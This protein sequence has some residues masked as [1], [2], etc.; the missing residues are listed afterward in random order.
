GAGVVAAGPAAA[1]PSLPAGFAVQ[2]M[3]SGQS[4]MLT[5]VAFAP[6]GSYFTTGKNGRV[7]WVAAT[8]EAR[9]LAELAVV[10]TGELGLISVAVA[11][12]YESS[13][14]V[15]T[16][17]SLSVG[18][19]SMMR[20]SAWTVDDSSSPTSLTDERVIWDLPA[21][22]TNHGT[23]G[24]VPDPDGTLWV[25]IG[26]N[27]DFTRVDTQA[28]RALD[29]TVGYGKVL[30]VRPDGR[31]VP[32]NPFY[33]PAAPSSWQS[34][35]YASGFRAPFRLSLDPR[36]GEPVVGDVGWSSWEEVDLA[37]PGASYGWPCWEGRTA[38]PGYKD[39]AACQGVR[40]TEPLWTYAHGPLGACVIGGVVYTGR[41]Y[42][43]QYRGA[44]FFGDYSSRRL[45]TLRYDAWGQLTRAP[46]DAGFG[47]DNGDPVEFGAA[48]NGDI[49]YA[50][51]GGSTLKRLVYDRG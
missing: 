7:A 20:V 47:V 17:R 16:V 9:T 40:N 21:T 42:P 13:G 18:G 38:T 23:T 51:V 34:R 5:D 30:H 3:P 29:T 19:Q 25:S 49:V 1:A 11:S 26:D 31:G 35:V 43:A 6:D 12:D 2:D 46:E 24:L 32:G 45:Y 22:V 36:T 50:D 14:E 48:P 8:G 41:S 10:T 27:S 37:G 28:L 44:Y 4:A 33:D 39:L 15:Y